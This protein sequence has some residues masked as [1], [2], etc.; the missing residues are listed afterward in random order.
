MAIIVCCIPPFYFLIL[1]SMRYWFLQAIMFIAK[2]LIKYHTVKNVF[3][4]VNSKE[5][6]SHLF[7][8]RYYF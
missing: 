2:Y 8:L 5:Y 1:K 6:Q 3:K 4:N 7:N